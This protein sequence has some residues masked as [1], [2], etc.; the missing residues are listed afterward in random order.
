VLLFQAKRQK[1]SVDAS[2]NADR[3]SRHLN[4]SLSTCMAG[5][6]SNLILI[7][8]PGM[9]FE[10]FRSR[11]QNRHQRRTLICSRSGNIAVVIKTIGTVVRKG[12]G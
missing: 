7:E 6:L 4:V 12:A 1:D 9:D 3:Y 11:L 2:M 5:F 10:T 8:K